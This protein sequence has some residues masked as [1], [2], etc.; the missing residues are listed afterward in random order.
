MLNRPSRL[1]FA[2]RTP[3]GMAA[4]ALACALLP[5]PALAAESAAGAALTEAPAKGVL[6][7]AP[8]LAIFALGL[9]GVDY[10]YGGT[11]PER[12]FDCSGL[13][14]YVFQEVAGATLPRTSREMA[15]RGGR[16][17]AGDLRPG[18]LVFFDT[19]MAPFSHVGIYIGDDRFV[20][21]PHRGAKVEVA[22][23]TQSYWRQRYQGARRLVGALPDIPSARAEPPEAAGAAPNTNPFGSER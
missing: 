12:G 1:K 15:Q 2:A 4:L 11:S 22:A 18:D 7:S 14:R 10:R 16:V 5:L 6:A 23:M 19:L 9:V 13:V 21:A 20:H 17:A 8:E 3:M